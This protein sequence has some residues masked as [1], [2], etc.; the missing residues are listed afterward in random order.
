MVEAYGNY[1]ADIATMF[2]ADESD[3]V[4]EMSKVL[5]FEIELA[6]VSLTKC[7]IISYTYIVKG[8]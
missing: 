1:M 5:D 3:A 7:L 4:E 2:G 6:G 8:G